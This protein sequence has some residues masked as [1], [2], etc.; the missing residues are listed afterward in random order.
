MPP[1][2]GF[3]DLSAKSK[4]LAVS[5]DHRQHPVTYPYQDGGC[6]CFMAGSIPLSLEESG[7]SAWACDG[8]GIG[9]AA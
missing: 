3:R 5:S 9:R 6:G 1:N 8:G 4:F 7:R 2:P